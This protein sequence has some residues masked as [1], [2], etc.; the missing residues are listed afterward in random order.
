MGGSSI[1]KNMKNLLYVNNDKRLFINDIV[2]GKKLL[3]VDAV[4]TLVPVVK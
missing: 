3:T 1:D 4:T 2:L